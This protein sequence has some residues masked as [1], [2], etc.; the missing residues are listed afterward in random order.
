MAPI[1]AP[2][3]ADATAPAAADAA[4]PYTLVL[5]PSAVAAADAVNLY[6]PE[7]ERCRLLDPLH[8]NWLP[9]ACGHTT[10]LPNCGECVRVRTRYHRYQSG[11]RDLLLW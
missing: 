5:H 2:A 9:P 3:A 4:A 10:H 7:E 11:M 6:S 1:A 8:P